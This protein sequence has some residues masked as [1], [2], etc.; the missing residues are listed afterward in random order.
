MTSLLKGEVFSSQQMK[1]TN[2]E[3]SRLQHFLEIFQFCSTK[4]KNGQSFSPAVVKVGI[5]SL[6]WTLT[7][8][9]NFCQTPTECRVS[10]NQP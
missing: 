2:N 6:L 10:L 1:E 5:W 4:E 9:L 8:I 7:M 3:V